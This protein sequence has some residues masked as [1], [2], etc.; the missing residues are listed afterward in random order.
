MVDNHHCTSLQISRAV[1]VTHH[2]EL[3][4]LRDVLELGVAVQKQRGVVGVGKASLVQSLRYKNN[5]DI[6]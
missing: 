4:Q 6:R 3:V 5:K 1:Q 2:N